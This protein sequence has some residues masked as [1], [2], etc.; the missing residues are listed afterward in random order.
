MDQ[1]KM[2]TLTMQNTRCYICD[3]FLHTPKQFANKDINTNL[4][5]SCGHQFHYVC[6][7]TTPP[8]SSK[9]K[10]VGIVRGCPIC[11][12]LDKSLIER[13]LRRGRDIYAEKYA[14]DHKKTLQRSLF[15]HHHSLPFMGTDLIQYEHELLMFQNDY[16]FGL[17]RDT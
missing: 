4:R 15:A 9:V 2:T 5:L 12:K 14:P 8:E 11:K 16:Y 17:F 7:I 6:M 10:H 13:M 3:E 1:E